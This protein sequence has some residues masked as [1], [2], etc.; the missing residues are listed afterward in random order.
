MFSSYSEF[1]AT[2]KLQKPS[3]SE[4]YTPVI[5]NLRYAETTYW[6]CKT[7]KKKKYLVINTE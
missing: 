6:V 5:F 3:D 1:W 7:E 2:E 4:C